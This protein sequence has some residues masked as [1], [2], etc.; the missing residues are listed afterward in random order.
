MYGNKPHHRHTRTAGRA[1]SV[2][3]LTPEWGDRR[4]TKVSPAAHEP[5]AEVHEGPVGT[6]R[7]H[8]EPG[9]PPSFEDL[10]AIGPPRTA[11]H[12]AV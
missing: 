2:T 1:L 11:S 4:V 3:A 10:T 8:T 6:P 7:G 5:A 9:I 12:Q